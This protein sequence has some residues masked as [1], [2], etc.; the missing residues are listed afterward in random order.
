M[1]AFN[2]AVLT[3]APARVWRVKP[4]S[5]ESKHEKQGCIYT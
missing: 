1:Y 3:G 4:T 2:L 5:G